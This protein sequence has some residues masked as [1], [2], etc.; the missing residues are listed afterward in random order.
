MDKTI[1]KIIL[2]NT[3][4]KGKNKHGKDW[5]RVDSHEL[6]AFIGV[7]LV[8]G[9]KSVQDCNVTHLWQTGPFQIPFYA[10]TMSRNRFTEILLCLP[11]DNNLTRICCKKTDKLAPI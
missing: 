10:G 9:L 11:F 4:K 7:L 8:M 3:N 6:D 5:D 1:Y 2:T